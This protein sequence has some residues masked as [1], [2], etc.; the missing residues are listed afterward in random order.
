MKE[1][2]KRLG[3][4]P[5]G[6]IKDSRDITNEKPIKDDKKN[7][8]SRK[9]ITLMIRE[10]LIDKVYKYAWWERIKKSEAIERVL[11]D[12]LKGKKCTK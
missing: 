11:S 6:W 10:D 2:T 12:G 1:K 3:T 9:R 7:K 5:L 8:D 4:D